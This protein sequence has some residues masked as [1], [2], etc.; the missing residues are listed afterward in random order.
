MKK[1]KRVFL[2]ALMAMVLSL[3]AALP[4]RAFGQKNNNRPPKEPEK[5]KQPDKP[6]RGNTNTQGN[7]NRRGRP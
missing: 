6:P 3:S 5:V 2:A 4:M 7:S 1:M